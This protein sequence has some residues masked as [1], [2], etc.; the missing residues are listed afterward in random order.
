MAAKNIYAKN[1]IITEKTTKIQYY[2]VGS[3]DTY[4]MINYNLIEAY[5]ILT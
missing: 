3:V 5:I 4:W 2:F 1:K